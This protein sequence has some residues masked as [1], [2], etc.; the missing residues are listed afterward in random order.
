MPVTQTAQVTRC[1][2]ET[3]GKHGTEVDR[4]VDSARW[5]EAVL[6]RGVPAHVEALEARRTR[7]LHRLD[8]HPDPERSACPGLV[9]RSDQALDGLP[10]YGHGIRRYRRTAGDERDRF[11]VPTGKQLGPDRAQ[12]V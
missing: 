12:V 6:V 8:E 1:G 10:P 4:M 3:S 5:S 9:P 7:R 11:E 2:V